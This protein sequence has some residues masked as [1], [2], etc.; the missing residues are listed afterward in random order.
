M[1]LRR[2]SY[3]YWNPFGREKVNGNHFTLS[4]RL[5]WSTESPKIPYYKCLRGKLPATDELGLHGT[6]QGGVRREGL[7]AGTN[8][9]TTDDPIVP[10]LS[11][12]N[13]LFLSRVG[14]FKFKVYVY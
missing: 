8:N 13:C 9:G 11:G 1:S 4:L 2:G 6:S 3:P 10:D 7:R 12:L 14:R 5:E